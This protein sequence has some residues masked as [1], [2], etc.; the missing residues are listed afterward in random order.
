MADPLDALA[1]SL[2]SSDFEV[3]KAKTNDTT[4][5][6]PRLAMYKNRGRA[7][8]NQE[9]RRRALLEHQKKRRTEALDVARALVTGENMDDDDN[10]T[11]DEEENKEA[12]DTTTTAE[13]IAKKYRIRKSYKKQLM[14]S[15]WMVEVPDDL[16]ENWVMVPVPQGRRTLVVAG[17]GKS[18]RYTR[19]GHDLG[20]FR[21]ALSRHKSDR[22]VVLDTIFVP[23]TGTFYVLD[24][25]VF[26]GQTF[27]DC[28]TDFRF[29][30]GKTHL[31]DMG[32]DLSERS[33][34]NYYAFR[35]LQHLPADPQSIAKALADHPE[36]S[37]PFAFSPETPLD[38]LLFY[39]RQLNY[40]P[41]HTP[42]VSW[43]KAYMVPE[44]LGVPVGQA[45]MAQKPANYMGMSDEIANFE[46]KYFKKKEKIQSKQQHHNNSFNKTEEKSAKKQQEDK[47][48]DG[49]RNETEMENNECQ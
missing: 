15:E 35:N 39:H 24:V 7:E 36:E 20:P 49:E 29:D 19:H 32:P 16:A 4:K 21:S 17:R 37:G 26:N 9:Q 48:D 27:Y 2:A 42:L 47:N 43:L 40:M 25:M 44:I 30:W 31:A 22:T 11:D 13:A 14:L 28:D 6:H 5:D 8:S 12:M 23:A 41:G 45:L 10:D 34:S 18:R 33:P 3:S 46:R 1:S 38:G